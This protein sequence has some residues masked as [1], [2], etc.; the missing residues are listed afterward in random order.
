MHPFSSNE[1]IIILEELSYLKKNYSNFQILLPDSTVDSFELIKKS[2]LIIVMSSMTGLEAA[3]FKKNVIN[4]TNSPYINFKITTKVKNF[5][6]LNLLL[7]RCII[8]KNFEDFP[9]DEEKYVGAVNFIHANLNNN[10]K[11]K[12]IIKNNYKSEAML[13]NDRYNQ[14]KATLINIF[15]YKLYCFMRFALKKISINI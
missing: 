15:L 3:Y 9:T 1:S 13:K 5:N 2:D 11:S 4:L 14:I 10:F 7:K 6:E 8:D 12:F